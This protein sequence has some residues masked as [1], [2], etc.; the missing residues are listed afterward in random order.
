MVPPPI[1][2]IS[3][4]IYGAVETYESEEDRNLDAKGIDVVPGSCPQHMSHDQW[5]CPGLL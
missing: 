5:T 2:R 4:Y 3:S 1:L